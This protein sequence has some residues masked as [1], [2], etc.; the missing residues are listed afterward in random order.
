M[1]RI[2]HTLFRPKRRTKFHF[3]LICVIYYSDT[4]WFLTFT[5]WCLHMKLFIIILPWFSRILLLG[6]TDIYAQFSLIIKILIFLII[7]LSVF[8]CVYLYRN[9]EKCNSSPLWESFNF[10][11]RSSLKKK[12]KNNRYL[13]KFTE[14]TAMCYLFSKC[15]SIL[16]MKHLKLSGIKCIFQD[17]TDK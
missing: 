13:L 15:L 2:R 8:V 16:L 14:N 12:K 11:N 3:W 17:H 10:P 9:R 1:V 6:S 4:L 7:Y 5:L